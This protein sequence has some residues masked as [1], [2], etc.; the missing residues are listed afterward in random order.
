MQMSFSI[1]RPSSIF[2]THP[3]AIRQRTKL[4]FKI[5]ELMLSGLRMSPH[6]IRLL[7]L[8]DAVRSRMLLL[9]ML[10]T[11]TMLPMHFGKRTS[12]TMLTLT[13]VSRRHLI[14]MKVS[15]SCQRMGSSVA[16]GLLM[17]TSL[18]SYIQ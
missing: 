7:L 18:L 13:S 1:L 9:L 6:F 12:P 14:V 17:L 8:P 15:F 4:C 16:A 11:S 3:Q 5:G 2:L 10:T